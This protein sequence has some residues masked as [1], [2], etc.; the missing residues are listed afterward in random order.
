MCNCFTRLPLGAFCG[1]NL[2]TVLW[3]NAVEIISSQR[4]QLKKKKIEQVNEKW[5][6]Q[7]EEGKCFQEG[8][9]MFSGYHRKQ[10]GILKTENKPVWP[11]PGGLSGTRCTQSRRQD[12]W[13]KTHLICLGFCFS[14]HQLL[15]GS[16]WLSSCCFWLLPFLLYGCLNISHSDCQERLSDWVRQPTLMTVWLWW[17]GFSQPSIQSFLLR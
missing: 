9:I 16:C 6:R 13:T 8:R 10:P 5:T 3:D 15:C 1:E 17:T 2:C 4:G 11:E 14:E 12:A 7:R